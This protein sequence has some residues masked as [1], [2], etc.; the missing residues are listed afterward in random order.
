MSYNKLLEFMQN[1]EMTPILIDAICGD[2]CPDDIDCEGCMGF[3]IC[4]IVDDQICSEGLKFMK[5]LAQ[6][7]CKASRL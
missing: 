5:N 3:E 1:Q 2:E 7:W 4:S 6:E